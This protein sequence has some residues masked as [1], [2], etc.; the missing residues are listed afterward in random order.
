MGQELMRE[1]LQNGNGTFTLGLNPQW[2]G[3]LFVTFEGDFGRATKK[4]IK[5]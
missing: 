2:K 3:T 4:V 1:E 5:L